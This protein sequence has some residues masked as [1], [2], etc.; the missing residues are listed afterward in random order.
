MPTSVPGDDALMW[1]YMVN[2]R[3]YLKQLDCCRAG[4]GGSSMGCLHLHLPIAHSG[5]DATAYSQTNPIEPQSG[6]VRLLARVQVTSPKLE[7]MIHL[8]GPVSRWSRPTPPTDQRSV[9]EMTPSQ[10]LRLMS[11]SKEPQPS[12]EQVVSDRGRVT[13]CGDPHLHQKLYGSHSKFR[14]ETYLRSTLLVST[15]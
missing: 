5:M 13:I 9:A 8:R 3:L 4:S 7:T 14:A 6:T 12:H 11:A 2:L 1:R 10:W 15:R